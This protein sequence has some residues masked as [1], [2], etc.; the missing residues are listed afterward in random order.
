MLLF[1]EDSDD[2]DIEGKVDHKMPRYAPYFV[3]TISCSPIDWSLGLK[4]FQLVVNVF[5]CCNNSYDCW[6]VV[7]LETELHR[8]NTAPAEVELFKY[9]HFRLLSF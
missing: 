2:D 3:I 5:S 8:S 9:T 4:T 7:F 1:R 6:M